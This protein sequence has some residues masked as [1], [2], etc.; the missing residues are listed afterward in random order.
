MP[1]PDLSDLIERLEHALG[2]WD[3]VPLRSKLEQ[4]LDKVAPTIGKPS[5]EYSQWMLRRTGQA[6]YEIRTIDGDVGRGDTPADAIQDLL[7]YLP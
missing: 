4:V 3:P 2:R 6:S 1:A 5:G 7:A